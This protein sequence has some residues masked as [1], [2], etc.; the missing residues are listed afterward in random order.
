MKKRSILLMILALLFTWNVNAKVENSKEI[1]TGN[2]QFSAIEGNNKQNQNTF[3]YKDSDFT[4]SSFI[5]SKSLEVLSIQVAGA[6]LS[7]Y[8]EKEDPYE[9]NPAN[10]AYNIR[11]FLKEMKFNDVETNKYYDTEKKENSV[12]AIIGQKTIIE[13]GESYTL[14]AVFPRSAGYKQEW[15]GNFTIG[16]GDIHEGFKSARD[17]ILRF[18]K[19]YI[20]KHNIK[21][22]L[23]I[24]TS[25]YSRGAAISNM[26]GGFFAGGGIEYFGSD[27]SITPRDVYC[28]TIGTPSS[29]KNGVSKNIELS[30]SGN[31]DGDDYK[32]DTKG[33]AFNY[34]KGGTLSL[35][36][37]V[38]GGVR[39]IISSDDAFPLL[40]PGAWGFTV[41]GKVISS[42]DGLSSEEDALKELKK[43]SEYVYDS[44]TDNGKSKSFSIKSF[45]LTTLEI[46]EVTKNASQIDFVKER[47]SG[48]TAKIA[49]NKAFYDEHY[50]DA[51]KSLIGT[52]GMVATIT[53]GAGE[54]IST[55]DIVGPLIYSYFAYVSTEL[56][57]EGIAHSE[58]EAITIAF[59]KLLTYFTGQVIDD[60][61]FTIDEFIKLFTK[62][63]SDNDDKP[64]ADTIIS[65]II[66]MVPYDYQSLLGIFKAFSTKTS[67][68][69]EDGIKAFF[70]ACYYGPDPAS[71]AALFY[72]D[73]VKVRELL[74]MTMIFAV[75]GQYPDIEDLLHGENDAITG[76]AKFQEFMDVM[77]KMLRTEKDENGVEVKVY[78]NM[79]ELADDKLLALIDGVLPTIIEKSEELYGKEYRNDLEKH[80]NNLKQNISKA[81]EVLIILFMHSENGYDTKKAIEGAIT[82]IDN[83][84]QIAMPH[85]D[86]IYLALSRHSTRYEEI[87]DCI[88]GNGQ[89]YDLDSE[90]GLK[91]VFDFDYNTFKEKGKLF[92]DNEEVP[93]SKYTIKEGSTIVILNE[94]YASSLS[95]GDHD[96]LAQ[97]DNFKVD[98]E[99]TVSQTKEEESEILPGGKDNDQDKKETTTEEIQDE[100]KLPDEE[101]KEEVI[102][103]EEDTPKT[104]DNIYVWISIM[105]ISISLLMSS[106]YFIKKEIK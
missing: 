1:I 99:F 81:R 32:N 49:T 90:E 10:N 44:Y 6:S 31:R 98:A 84:Y 46:V 59:E 82:F 97:M 25:G 24:W 103:P 91:F 5:G 33:E 83:A 93:R 20:N 70:K 13:D 79:A 54:G 50:Q 86:E 102:V 92:I 78:Q 8:G 95:K 66:Q 104:F 12:G 18:T 51:L 11:N 19:E 73:D 87:Y 80:V 57:E 52:Y 2:Y 38:Y 53:S 60:D 40:P 9:L 74:Y 69:T 4:K 30:V 34:T 100:T 22:K 14:L 58:T 35:D 89:E 101:Q 17:E 94:D 42:R 29:V 56:Q 72:A 41:Y 75:G 39:N 47:F 3:V 26:L 43:I 63:I 37:E 23:K 55:S 85:F 105:V 62:Y 21:G 15:V 64:I 28:Y 71:Q 106:T 27:V 88:Y 68:T 48:L 67:P 45:D 77:L 7:W 65:E 96:L 16:D 61:T 76:E 36:D